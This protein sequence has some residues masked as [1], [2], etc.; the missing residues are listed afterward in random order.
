MLFRKDRNGLEIRIEARTIAIVAAF[1]LVLVGGVNG[2]SLGP[3][4]QAA[5]GLL[6]FLR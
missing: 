2:D 6:R 3:A 5:A 1:V 4:V